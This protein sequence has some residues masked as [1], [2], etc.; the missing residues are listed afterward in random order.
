MNKSRRIITLL[1]QIGT[2]MLVLI[3]IYMI[4][5]LMDNEGGMDGIF[6]MLFIQPLLAVLFSGLTV[7][8]CIL[9]G[10]PLRLF[11]R[12]NA[13]WR[14]RLYL[15]LILLATG[16]ILL[17]LSVV[18]IFMENVT[19]IQD[20]LNSVKTIPNKAFAISGWFL[21]AFS[22]LHIFQLKKVNYKTKIAAD[23]HYH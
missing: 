13:W 11:S 8:L 7:I 23:D 17:C 2:T 15:Q 6:G 19:Y 18:P 21:T 12:I 4:F 5:S 22:I 1:I 10:L 9:V 3:L 16:I 14:N 20:G